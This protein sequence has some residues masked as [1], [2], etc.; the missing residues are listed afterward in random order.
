MS[1]GTFSTIYRSISSYVWVSLLFNT[2]AL[3]L[4]ID[5][6]NYNILG[7]LLFFHFLFSL[8]ISV[9][10]SI[11][12]K[13]IHAIKS[14]I[15][16]TLTIWPSLGLITLHG[17][18]SIFQVLFYFTFLFSIFISITLIQSRFRSEKKS[19]QFIFNITFLFF[20]W[21]TNLVIESIPFI[22]EFIGP[23][24]VA[25]HYLLVT[26]GILHIGTI[27]YMILL[28]IICFGLGYEKK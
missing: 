2:F 17:T 21:G 16:H 22:Y 4:F 25:Y 19:F 28:M 7:P 18:V 13:R 5:I 20:L 12:H 15:L 3:K 8:L 1:Q 26:E 6:G 11:F 14:S 10:F 23:L 27:L 9:S 24:T